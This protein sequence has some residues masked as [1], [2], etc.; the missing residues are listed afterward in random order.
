MTIGTAA[1]PSTGAAANQPAVRGMFLVMARFFQGKAIL[2][3]DYWESPAF[4][5]LFIILTT[6]ASLK[7]RVIGTRASVSTQAVVSTLLVLVD[8]RLTVSV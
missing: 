7:V 6:L 2:V 5:T 4:L 1:P 8:L 3:G